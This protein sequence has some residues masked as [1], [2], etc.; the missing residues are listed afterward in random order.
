MINVHNLV[1][2]FQG[3]AVESLHMIAIAQA[4]D[5]LWASQELTGGGN[6]C[7]TR[8]QVGHRATRRERPASPTHTLK[9]GRTDQGAPRVETHVDGQ[10]L[11]A[12][13]LIQHLGG[14]QQGESGLHRRDG[15]R[16]LH[17]RPGRWP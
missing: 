16:A 11:R 2:V 13:A 4:A 5:S 12:V 9:A 14:T 8:R 6:G 10:G 7:Q 17:R 1:E 3:D 15:M